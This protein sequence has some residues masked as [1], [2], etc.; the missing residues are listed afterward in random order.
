MNVLVELDGYRYEVF[1][2]HRHIIKV[3]I[4]TH[5]VLTLLFPL[6]QNICLCH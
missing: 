3:Y 1:M 6:F 4:K 5:L 2:H